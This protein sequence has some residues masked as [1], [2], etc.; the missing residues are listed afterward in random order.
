MSE[1][2]IGE[3]AKL[4][5]VTPRTIRYYVE[6]GLLSPP[7]GTGRVATYGPEHLSRIHTI[8]K[9]QAGR[10]SLDEIRDQLASMTPEDAQRVATLVAPPPESAVDYIRSLRERPAHYGQPDYETPVSAKHEPGDNYI[11]EP[12]TRIP[13]SEDVELHVKRRGNRIDRRISKLVEE[14]RRI[15][16]EEEPR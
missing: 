16:S 1:W 15:L 5:G 11:S 6:L 14:G 3:F 7:H 8:R 13:L 4:T 2:S 9:F 10:L 12:W